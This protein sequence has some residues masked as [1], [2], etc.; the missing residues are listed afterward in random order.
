MSKVQVET[1][2]NGEGV[3]FLCEPQQTL[4]EVLRET[5]SLSIWSKRG[6]PRRG[7]TPYALNPARL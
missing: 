4:L 5:L 2:I 6:V 7:E 1:R 3:E